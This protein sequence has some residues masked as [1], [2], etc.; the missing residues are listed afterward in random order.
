MRGLPSISIALLLLYCLAAVQAYTNNPSMILLPRGGGGG[1]TALITIYDTTAS[2]SDGFS[3]PFSLVDSNLVV[4]GGAIKFNLDI[5]C[6]ARAVGQSVWTM[7]LYSGSGAGPIAYS[8]TFRFFF[9]TPA[10][11]QGFS[12]DWIAQVPPGNY[13]VR[14]SSTDSN[15]KYDYNDFVMLTAEDHDINYIR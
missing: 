15:T 2:S 3:A 11:H 9:N 14:L 8:R 13:V 7:N 5:S 1:K 4:T 12:A 6:W 10:Q